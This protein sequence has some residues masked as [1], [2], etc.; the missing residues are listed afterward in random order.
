[1]TE[2]EKKM[3]TNTCKDKALRR[4]HF[5][6]GWVSIPLLVAL[7]MQCVAEYLT[8]LNLWA[9]VQCSFY[10]MDHKKYGQPSPPKI[11]RC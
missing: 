4:D 9:K 10:Y 11:Q 1:M 5:H 8:D 3:Q 7:I 2:A 6:L